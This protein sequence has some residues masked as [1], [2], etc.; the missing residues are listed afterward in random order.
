MKIL[1]VFRGEGVL[2]LG[3]FEWTQAFA[4]D[5][6]CKATVGRVIDRAHTIDTD[7]ESYP[8]MHCG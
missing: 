2:N 7:K 1:L 6:L 3:F 8:W 4:N 5:R